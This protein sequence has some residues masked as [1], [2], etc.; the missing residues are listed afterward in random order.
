MAAVVGWL[1]FAMAPPRVVAGEPATEFLEALRNAGYYDTALDYLD[2]MERSS[3]APVAFR[4][5]L[6]YERGMTLI[7]V[8]G[9]ELDLR[10]REQLLDR[11]DA[12]LKR[13]IAQDPNH[14]LAL[15]ARNQ[16]GALLYLRG[17]SR[18]EQA[19]KKQN[20]AGLLAE[21]RAF[22]D[23]AQQLFQEA[24][25]DL[26]ARLEP[27][28]NRRYSPQEREQEERR[29][30]LRK[31]YLQ[32]QMLA[33]QVLE[34]RAETFAPGSPQRQ[35]ALEEAYAA[36]QQ[37]SEKYRTLAAG[38]VAKLAMA[39]CRQKQEKWKEAIGLYTE[40]LDDTNSPDLRALHTEALSGAMDCWLDPSQNL[41]A[42][43]IARAEKWQEQLR[44]AEQRDPMALQVRYKLALAKKRYADSL[45]EKDPG[46]RQIPEL[47]RSAR[48]LAVEVSRYPSPVQEAALQLVA[49]IRGVDAAEQS[50][51]EPKT[52]DEALQAARD[53][54]TQM[55]TADFLTRSLPERLAQE[56]DPQVRNEVLQQLEKARQDV[57]ARRA[58]AIR[59][60]RLV[61][62]LAAP[63][64][65]LETINLA[66]L[67]LA[68]LS[69]LNDDFLD[70]AVLGSF[71]ASKYPAQ[72]IS[73]D[74]ASIALAAYVKLY[75][76]A[77]E[78]ERQDAAKRVRQVAE[79]IIRQWPD[80]PVAADAWNALIPFIVQ[81]GD[82]DRAWQGLQAIPESMP[83]R[84]EIELKL[85]R[86][87]W[88][89]YRQGM[90]QLRQGER[91]GKLG[92]PDVAE[93]Q[94]QLDQYRDQAEKVLAAGLQR[95]QQGG[96]R[97]NSLLLAALALS[98]LY[99]ETQRPQEAVTLLEHPQFGPLALVRAKDPITEQ[100]G[101]AE[102]TYRTALRAYLGTMVAGDKPDQA[103]QKAKQVMA[104]LKQSVGGGPDAAQRL[105]AIYL[106]MARELKQQLEIASDRE[107]L[108]LAKGFEVFLQELASEAQDFQI[109][110]WV[111]E[112][113]ATLAESFDVPDSPVAP[114]TANQFYRR[115]VELLRGM[116]DEAE[117]NPQFLPEPR[118]KLLLQMRLAMCLRRIGD[119]QNAMNTWAEILSVHNTALSVQVEAARTL[120]QWA[121]MPGQQQM[122]IKAMVGDRP[123]PKAQPPS[124]IIWG[125]G[126]IGKLTAGHQEFQQ[127]FFESRL[128]L[129]ECRFEYARSVKDANQQ[130][131][132]LEMAKQDIWF[133]YRLYP[134]L[135]G[136]QFREKYDRL[137]RE[138]QKALGERA[139][140][141]AEF[142]RKLAESKSSG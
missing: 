2:Q 110:Q 24:Q 81:E 105:V 85:G 28:N 54:Y 34:E 130:K 19:R 42:E 70:A 67:S 21:A 83:Q 16:L 52:L 62:Q 127:V 136:D 15:A 88:A 30:Q 141:L 44:P 111:A 40:L 11:A 123:D 118:N 12:A 139:E 91:E 47:L 101:V 142:Q 57:A 119:Y 18:I 84:A 73:R 122:Y 120:Q 92:G 79:M 46:N 80:Q 76:D 75:T 7:A 98:Q 117:R 128:A 87:L 25:Q 49:D 3:L 23:Q 27:I 53:A 60:Y 77:G 99:L 50:R 103:V 61:L 63:D 17:Q 78:N 64:T 131:R 37:I 56:T 20:D 94:R 31:D 116:L 71:L 133:T 90:A 33:A 41:F 124:N 35:Q 4:Q 109:R 108:D 74:A 125:W 129:A 89:A 51:A 6:D 97:D 14:R 66:R 134:E 39:R 55:Q 22:L 100:P 107:R 112:T 106:T 114:Q 140:G 38:L 10:A 135:G 43:A 5:V 126:K 115:A 132:Y 82:F 26:R 69:Y 68:H 13:F 137:L 102:E 45:K 1:V 72:S 32:A 8:A 93:K 58:D 113:F 138:V 95:V 59:Y 86:A 36:F 96:R 29:D 65:P 9:T 121:K 48:Y 104:E